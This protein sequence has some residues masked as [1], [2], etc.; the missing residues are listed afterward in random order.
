MNNSFLDIALSDNDKANFLSRFFGIF[1]EG[2]LGFWLKSQGFNLKGRP[3][4][5][6]KKDHY[7][8]KTFD[9]TIEKGGKTFIVEAKCYIAYQ[10]YKHLELTL[11][12]LEAQW[13]YPAD[14]A[15]QLFLELGKEKPY[16]KYNFYCGDDDEPF[17]PDG[18]ILI[19]AKVKKDEIKHIKERYN[20]S[21]I[22]SV[23]EMI[24]GIKNEKGDGY[25]QFVQ[26]RK[27]W[28]NELFDSLLEK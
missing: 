1:Y 9:Y 3:S 25:F 21:D 4:V 22:F 18:K 19:W 7:L 28:T 5:Y 12:L 14:N 6:N 15:F 11:D 10:N 24:N 16:E 26:D 2:L 17:R 23:E 8:N 13:D 20:F 27:S